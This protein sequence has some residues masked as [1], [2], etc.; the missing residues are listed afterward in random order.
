VLL[1]L[2]SNAI[3]YN[4]DGGNVVVDLQSINSNSARIYVKDTGLGIPAEKLEEL[5]QPF[6]RLNAE[7][8]GIEGTG[9]GLTI[10]KSIVEL[11][12]GKIG[13]ESTVGAGSSF[14]IELRLNL[15]STPLSNELSILTEST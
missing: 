4:V 2:L 12:G 1:N 11:M 14:W 10:T 15:D 3:K 13:V 8:S 9:I 6:N 5:F 7:N